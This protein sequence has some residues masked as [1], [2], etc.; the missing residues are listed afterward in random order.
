MLPVPA[1]KICAGESTQLFVDVLE[2]QAPFSINW[3]DDLGTNANVDVNPATTT[4]YSVSVT[5]A[6]NCLRV[7]DV[8]VE[9]WE[10]IDMTIESTPPTCGMSNGSITGTPLNVDEAECLV[11]R[12]Y[13]YTLEQW[14]GDYQETPVFENLPAGSYRI[15]KWLDPNCD[16]EYSDQTCLQDFPEDDLELVDQESP[17]LAFEQTNVTCA[18]ES[19]GTV[20]LSIQGGSSPFDII[21]N[22]G[23]DTRE[24]SGLAAGDYSVTITDANG[25][26]ATSSISIEEPAL[27]TCE[28]IDPEDPSGSGFENG[29]IDLTVSGG[30]TPTPTPGPTG[31]ETQDL[32]GVGAGT[33]SVTITDANGCETSCSATVNEPSAVSCEVTAEAVSCYEGEDGSLT[34]TG[35]GGSGAYEYSLNETDYTTSNTFTGLSAGIYTIFVRDANETAAVSSCQVEI[36]QPEELSLSQTSI[37]VSCNGFSDG[38]IDLTI[39]GGTT[40]YTY[41]WSTGS[42]NRRPQTMI[43]QPANTK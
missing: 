9:V 21:W 33:Y 18:G 17:S 16:G 20:I 1:T 40:P 5:D 34:V 14:M 19:D 28:S 7:G 25:C 11:Y 42:D 43:Y 12:L 35:E 37:Q 32:I 23:D 4:T 29:S 27:L 3:S 8:L 31:A 36:T 6:H 38:Q 2:G 15:K 39:S 24:L 30:T 13:N 10:A 22:T 41:Q 26:E